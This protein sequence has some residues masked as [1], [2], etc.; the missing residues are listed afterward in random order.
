MLSE[1][2]SASGGKKILLTGNPNVGKSA[3]FSRLTGIDVISDINQTGKL[4]N[5]TG[6]TS[7]A[8]I[9]DKTSSMQTIRDKYNPH[10]HTGNLGSPTSAP[11]EVMS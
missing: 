8:D 5:S 4:K 11:S 10:T 7:A 3:V 6:I 9:T 2:K 1:A